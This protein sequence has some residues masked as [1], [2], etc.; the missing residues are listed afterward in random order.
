MQGLNKTNKKKKQNGTFA[1]CR[2][3]AKIFPVYKHT[4]KVPRVAK[5]CSW[6]GQID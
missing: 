2:H 6:E 1:V 4:A 5:L 3:T